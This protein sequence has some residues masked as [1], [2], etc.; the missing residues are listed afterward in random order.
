MSAKQAIEIMSTWELADLVHTT[1]TFLNIPVGS[2]ELDYSAIA[3]AHAVRTIDPYLKAVRECEERRRDI[4]LAVGEELSKAAERR[5]V[6][7]AEADRLKQAALRQMGDYGVQQHFFTTCVGQIRRLLPLVHRIVGVDMDPKA[8]AILDTY[9]P[10]RNQFEHLDERLP[11]HEKGG[12]LIL[13]VPDRML[14]GLN[15]DGAGRITVKRE[16]VD[17]VAEVNKHGVEELERIVSESYD[18][19]R[20]KCF[21][22][23]EAFFS[24]NP[25]LTKDL[26]WLRPASAQ[27]VKRDDGTYD[28]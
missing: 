13:D 15:D 2:K 5:A 20:A 18:A 26:T 17:V 6:N 1:V 22:H 27:R 25:Q 8:I 24:A 11:G 3:A 14:I 9:Q 21:E 23:L 19:I 12:R 7:S 28:Q 4:G 16:G 10:L